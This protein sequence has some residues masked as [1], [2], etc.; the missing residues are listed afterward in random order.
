MKRILVIGFILFT[1]IYI[2]G[3][4]RKLIVQL[5]DGEKITEVEVLKGTSLDVSIPTKEGHTFL[6]WELDG[7]KY[8][9]N[10]EIK[11]NITLYAKWEVN[12]YTVTFGNTGDSL[13]EDKTIEYGKTLENIITPVQDGLEFVG[14]LNEDELFDLSTPITSDLV[15]IGLWTEKMYNISFNTDGGTTIENIKVPHGE[16]LE[17]QT[18]T[19]EHATFNGWLNNNELFD[20]NT[21]ITSNLNLVATWLDDYV[22]TIHQ[23]NGESDIVMYVKYGQSI[24]D[25]GGFPEVS[26]EGFKF[27][28]FYSDENCTTRVYET[29]ILQKDIDV[30]VKW[31][32]IFTIEYNFNGGEFE[33]EVIYEYTLTDI[34]YSDLELIVPSR[35]NYYFRGW[36][37]TE[38]FSDTLL[39][40]IKKDNAKHYVLY[41]KWAEATLQNAYVTIVGDSISAYEDWIP[42]GY[43]PCY[44]YT[45]QNGILGLED[46]WWRLT[47]RALGFKLGV[48]NAYAGTCVMKQYGTYSTE[49]ISRLEK[50]MP[51]NNIRPDIMI[52]Y[53]GNNDALVKDL[54]VNA[55]ETSYRNMINNIYKLFPN[56]QIFVSTMS[57]EKYYLSKT[58]QEYE[59]HLAIR[60]GVNDAVKKLA[61]EFNLP[62]I[63]FE[64]AYS[65]DSC[66]Y[67]TIHPNIKGMK[68]LS[69]V[70][71]KAMK[72]F[73]NLD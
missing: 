13:I 19:K 37:E 34:K 72:E 29:S 35:K 24:K 5:N 2:T 20:L 63:D 31:E 51:S 65:D 55:F 38:D 11:E 12:K 64:S 17:V 4:K 43:E 26:K 68:C 27:I 48:V 25:A 41:A 54:D 50:S 49:N 57:Y 73:Y 23:D 8:N 39:Y 62:I 16:T 36:F 44:V 42:K 28:N 14:W 45:K 7:K 40:K 71:V 3:C 10:S 69:E 52:L 53:I 59:A 46:M 9:I 15:L 58:T 61:E 6:Y 70:A 18:P 33:G 32:E 60:N 21:P 66:L 22:V 67:D 56:I 30:Y 1:M 47:Q